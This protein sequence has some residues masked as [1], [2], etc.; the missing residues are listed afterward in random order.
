MRSIAYFSL[1]SL[2]Y[3]V[4]NA[5]LETRNHFLIRKLKA[6]FRCFILKDDKTALLHSCA[7]NEQK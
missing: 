7:K 6:K 1:F 2:G 4:Y 3:W 5:Q